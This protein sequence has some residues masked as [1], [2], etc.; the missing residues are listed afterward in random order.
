M[1]A[2]LIDDL[3]ISCRNTLSNLA[4][5]IGLDELKSGAEINRILEAFELKYLEQKERL[6]RL[7]VLHVEMNKVLKTFKVLST[8]AYTVG[9]N[10]II[11]Y[12]KT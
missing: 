6:R 12:E 4:K 5:E 10:R 8:D 7:E 3:D 9:S 11:E 2:K 1:K